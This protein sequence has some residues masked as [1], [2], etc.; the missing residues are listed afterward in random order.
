MFTNVTGKL[1][2]ITDR[3]EA[4]GA[5]YFFFIFLLIFPVERFLGEFLHHGREGN[6]TSNNGAC[7]PIHMVHVR[8][9]DA[10]GEDPVHSMCFLSWQVDSLTLTHI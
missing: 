6:V 8:G 2:I 1:W 10:H 9:V 4:G 7:Y 3:C 5:F